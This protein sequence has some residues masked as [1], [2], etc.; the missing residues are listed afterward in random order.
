MSANLALPI[1]DQSHVADARRRA[2]ALVWDMDA[3]TA[4]VLSLV[5]TELSTNLLKH[6]QGGELLVRGLPNGIEILALD[7][8]PGIVDIE[9]S[10]ADGYST[11]GSSGTGLGAVRR[12]SATFDIQSTVGVGTAVLAR[13]RPGNGTPRGGAS[14][15]ADVWDI[16][17]VS[18]ARAGEDVCGDDWEAFVDRSGVTVLVVD[19]LGHGMGACAA[20]EAAINTFRKNHDLAPDVVFD[21]LHRALRPTRGAAVGLAR[22]DSSREVVTFNGVGNIAGTIFGETGTRQVVSLPGIVGHEVRKVA[23]F[24]Y[25]WSTNAVLVL[26]SDG[27]RSPIAAVD[28]YPGL[29]ARHPAL[30]AAL[31][32]RDLRRERDDATVVVIRCAR[33]RSR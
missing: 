5:I 28:R 7:Q 8:G 6:A 29:F 3:T 15:A 19:G 25:P 33:S 1:R 31:L 13:V 32:Y 4:G 26:H 16:G 11:A 14:E 21:G 30:V 9:R 18:V 17:G 27:V 2:A 20:A 22:V 24:T 23:E 12:L 10:L